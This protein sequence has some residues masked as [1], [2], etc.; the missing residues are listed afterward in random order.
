MLLINKKP[1]CI[2]LNEVYFSFKS[3]SLFECFYAFN[4]VDI[5]L[6]E[7]MT[8]IFFTK[9]MLLAKRHV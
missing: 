8:V 1:I 3:L 9:D 6:T 5:R 2:N 4:Q 7:S